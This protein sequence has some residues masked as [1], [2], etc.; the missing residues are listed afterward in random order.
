MNLSLTPPFTDPI[1]QSF[2][3]F[4]TANPWVYEELRNLAISLRRKGRK[5]YGI[6][7]LYEVVRFNRTLKLT[8]STE[9]QLNNNYTA[10]YSRLLMSQEPELRDFFRVRLRRAPESFARLCSSIHDS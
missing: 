6:K 8:T 2:W 5:N 7:A 3:Q 4:H 9:F 1:E 10:C